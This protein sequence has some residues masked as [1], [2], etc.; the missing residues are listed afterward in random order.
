MTIT[1]MIIIMTVNIRMFFWDSG[2]H[3][4]RVAARFGHLWDCAAVAHPLGMK[5]PR[6]DNLCSLNPT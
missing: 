1:I 4:S 5:H 2:T 3:G 6:P